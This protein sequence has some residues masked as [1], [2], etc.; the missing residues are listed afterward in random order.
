MDRYLAGECSPAE[1]EEIERWLAQEPTR[2]NLL[3]Q[4]AGPD[5]AEL[6]KARAE[7]WARLED[8]VRTGTSPAG[9]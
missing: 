2:R 8:Q 7:I 3:E 4:L 9:A 1:L 6:R 5:E